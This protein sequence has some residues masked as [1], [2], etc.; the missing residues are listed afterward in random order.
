M[1]ITVWKDRGCCRL[2]LL[3]ISY[4]RL[5]AKAV[6]RSYSCNPVKISY[7][8]LCSEELLISA[9]HYLVGLGS[10]IYYKGRLSECNA[11]TLTLSYSIMDD[12][13]VPAQYISINIYI[14]AFVIVLSGAKPYHSGIISVRDKA[15]ILTV[16]LSCIDK[17]VGFGYA[18][19]L[20]FLKLSQRKLRFAKLLLRH[21]I[22]HIALILAEIKCL[23][24]LERPVRRLLYPCIMTGHH[25][26]AAQN[27]GS[28]EKLVKFHITVAVYAGIRRDALLIAMYKLLYDFLIEIVCE[29]KYIIR[30]AQPAGNGTCILNII[31]GAAGMP[32]I[33]TCILVAVQ[34]HGA[35]RAVVALVLHYQSSYRGIHPSAHRYQCFFCHCNT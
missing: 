12:A 29:I 33:N 3:P 22:K 11:K 14:I 35:A 13:L 4:F 24:K 25:I 2:F 34:A 30:H 7:I 5:A 16:R 23:L 9:K 6:R 31:Q 19:H 20:G 28:I 32:L 17:S 27:L 26:V 21:G 1:H 18:A 8:K 15:D 10:D